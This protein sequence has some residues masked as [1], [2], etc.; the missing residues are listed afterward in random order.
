MYLGV[1][2]VLNAHSNQLIKALSSSEG[3]FAAHTEFIK[4]YGAVV[5]LSKK[6]NT[7]MIKSKTAYRYRHYLVCRSRSLIPYRQ[8]DFTF[9]DRIHIFSL[10]LPCFQFTFFSHF[11]LYVFQVIIPCCEFRLPMCKCTYFAKIATSLCPSWFRKKS[12]QA[13]KT[14]Q[15]SQLAW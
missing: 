7:P 13:N 6:K 1:L 8:T 11:L 12:K 4:L 9:H 2:R 14:K 3:S 15:K 5:T 10:H